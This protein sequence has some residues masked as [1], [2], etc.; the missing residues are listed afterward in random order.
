MTIHAVTVVR[1]EADIIST[2]VEHLLAEGVDRV[3]VLDHCSTDTTPALLG[4][5]AATHPDRVWV[6]R[7]DEPGHHQANRITTLAMQARAAGAEWV[8]PFD[9]DE[10]WYAPGSTLAEFFTDCRYDSV[11]CVGFDHICRDL[12]GGTVET[13]TYRRPYPQQIPKVAFR[14]SAR[15]YVD[16]GNHHVSQPG[17][18][19]SGLELRHFQYRSFDQMR[20]K[21]RQGARAADEAGQHPM[22]AAHWRNLA[23]L[24]DDELEVEWMTLCATDDLIHDP[25]PVSR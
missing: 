16:E 9:A 1:D 11:Q 25:A 2:T 8:I 22:Y 20:R 15:N 17:R 10:L 12:T 18:V 14:P 4:D 21:V 23:T 24:S 5:L 3:W 19:G 7:D 13:I 6:D